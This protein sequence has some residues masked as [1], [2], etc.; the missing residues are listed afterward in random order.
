MNHAVHFE[1]VNAD[2][3]TREVSFA[4]P[5]GALALLV[6][7]RREESDRLVRLL[8]GLSRPQAGRLSVLGEEVGAL[9]E[10]ALVA[11]RKSLSVVFSSGGLVSNLK[12]WE[13]LVLPLEYHFACTPSEIQEKGEAA[14]RRVG[15]CGGMMELP[16]HLSLCQKRQVGLARAMLSEPRLMIF[17]AMLDGLQDDEKACLTPAALEFHREQGGRT[18]LFITS[19]PESVRDIPFD[20]RVVLKE[21]ALHAE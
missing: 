19:N 20:L 5:P 18:S 17:D 15:Y 10:K 4:L 11:L 8:L 7:S 6:T 14:L 21:G 12:V 16:G 9:S 1:Q 2:D 13:N 3:L